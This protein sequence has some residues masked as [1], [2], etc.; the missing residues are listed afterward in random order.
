MSLAINTSPINSTLI[1]G[2][3]GVTAV[4]VTPQMSGT[5][6]TCV[7]R[8]AGDI[9]VTLPDASIAGLKYRFVMNSGAAVA[10]L[11]TFSSGANSTRGFW[12]SNVSAIALSGAL[13]VASAANVQFTATATGGDR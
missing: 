4:T 1:A 7:K 12:I 9:T 11:I 6:F 5:T 2:T 3:A 13:G 10:H 8:A